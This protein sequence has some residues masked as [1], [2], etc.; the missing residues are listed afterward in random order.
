[1][2]EYHLSYTL[3]HKALSLLLPDPSKP[4]QV[5]TD[6]NDYAIVVVLYE[7]GKPIIFESKKLD[8]I[9]CQYTIQENDIFAIIHA[10]Q[11]N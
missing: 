4:F 2:Y 9:Q 11:H 3:Y 10:L 1:M 8:S 5:E 6:A 7:D